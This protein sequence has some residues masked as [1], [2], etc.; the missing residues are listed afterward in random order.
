MITLRS[1]A[2]AASGLFILSLA[3]L[4]GSSGCASAN[5][6]AQPPSASPRP[7]IARRP[8]ES[9][10]EKRAE[11]DTLLRTLSDGRKVIARAALSALTSKGPQRFIATLRVRPSF[12]GKRFRGWRV[13]RY[14]GPG[15]LELGDIVVRVNNQPVER[16][17]QFMAVW[18]GLP[19]ASELKI[20]LLRQGQPH[21]FRWPIVDLRP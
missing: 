6:G 11:A 12:V 5:T 14:R 4:L 7:I 2:N 17:E 1:V 19:Q 18:A 13:L 9:S 10:K 15:R 16:P 21:V 20:E 8:P 3:Q